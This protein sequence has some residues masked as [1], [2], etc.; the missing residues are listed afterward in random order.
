MQGYS[1]LDMRD[2]AVFETQVEKLLVTTR[3]GVG[4]NYKGHH[5]EENT[6]PKQKKMR[7]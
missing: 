2:V 1:A 7:W 5:T 6:T 4:L 3:V